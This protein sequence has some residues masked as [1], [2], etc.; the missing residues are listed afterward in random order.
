MSGYIDLRGHQ[1]WSYRHNEGGE[2]VVVLHGGLSYSEKILPY[3]LPVFESPAL[4]KRKVFAYDRSGQGRTA[5][6]DGAFDMNFQRD[7]LISYLEDVVQEPAHLIGHS[8][9]ANCAVMAALAKQD[10]VKSVVAI[11]PSLHPRDAVI[12]FPTNP[13]PREEDQA[14]H[15]AL[16]PDS[17]DLFIKKLRECFEMWARDPQIEVA[18]LAALTVPTLFLQGDDDV[19]TNATAESYAKACRDGRLAIIAGASHDVIKEKTSLVQ[20]TLLDFYAN[21]EYPETKYPNWRH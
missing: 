20:A 10:L 15:D 17:P 4:G 19:I 3:L 16:S 14:E 1:I 7:E 8:D 11:G 18:D 13:Q 21:L 2:P 6:R 9:G 12:E 5:Y